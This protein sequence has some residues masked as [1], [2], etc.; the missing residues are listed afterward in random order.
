MCRSSIPYLLAFLIPASA[1]A[2]R[3]WSIPLCT[4]A[5]AFGAI[6]AVDVCVGNDDHNLSEEE[7]RE[8]ERSWR[9]KA[10]TWAWVP[11]Q[12]G[13][14]VWAAWEVC[15]RSAGLLRDADLALSV[16][17]VAGLGINVA[18]EMLHK[19]DG[20]NR[21]LGR[22]LLVATCYGHFAIGAAPPPPPLPPRL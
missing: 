7:E 16:G 4:F 18:H 15:F 8:L 5:F 20:P 10:V 6:P 14:L 9:F 12:L 13:V 2:G 17:I 3:V 21:A 22:L 19:L 1:V 11:V